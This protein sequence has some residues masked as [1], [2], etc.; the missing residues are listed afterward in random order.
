L[1]R[2]AL[3]SAP[4]SPTAY[5]DGHLSIDLERRRIRIRQRPVRLTPTEFRLLAYLCQHPNRV[6]TYDQILRN[7]WGPECVEAT[8]YVYVYLHR[9]RKKLE[10]D[11][12]QPRYFLTEPGIGCR[13]DQHSSTG[14]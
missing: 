5:D 14:A 2:S 12:G 1:R 9:L 10:A 8:Q 7:V 13:F 3:T 11:P 4:P 6:L